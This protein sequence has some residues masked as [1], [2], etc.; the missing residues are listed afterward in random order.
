MGTDLDGFTAGI[1]TLRAEWQ[2]AGRD[3]SMLQSQANIPVVRDRH[4]VPDLART[5]GGAGAWVDA[6]ATAKTSPSKPSPPIRPPAQ[7]SGPTPLEGSHPRP[8]I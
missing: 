2:L 8:V 6:G 4:G 1:A 7:P 5:I 3:P